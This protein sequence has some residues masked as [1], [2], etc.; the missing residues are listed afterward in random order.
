LEYRNTCH[1]FAALLPNYVL[2][3]FA[4]IRFF[5]SAGLTYFASLWLFIIDL[6]TCSFLFDVEIFLLSK[7]QFALVSISLTLLQCTSHTCH[8]MRVMLGTLSAVQ[9]S[10]YQPTYK[11]TMPVTS[12]LI[13]ILQR[14]LTWGSIFGPKSYEVI[15]KQEEKHMVW[16]LSYY[17]LSLENSCFH[18][19]DAFS[20][21]FTWL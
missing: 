14:W 11:R 9:A 5:N 4:S 20:Y 7:L 15:W 17:L 19:T 21:D 12:M 8:R 16:K 18:M 13:K 1:R 3:S 2:I 6:K 10:P